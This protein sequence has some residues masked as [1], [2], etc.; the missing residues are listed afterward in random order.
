MIRS[1]QN[2]WAQPPK[3]IP[4]PFGNDFVAH[5]LGRITFLDL[6]C[7]EAL[8][9]AISTFKMKM[10][11]SVTKKILLSCYILAES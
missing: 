6:D 1:N 10:V 5:C 3:P 9:Y 7:Y 11:L 8:Q 2:S 4:C